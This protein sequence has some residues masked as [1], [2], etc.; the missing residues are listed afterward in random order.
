MKHT[1]LIRDKHTL[2]GEPAPS[3]HLWVKAWHPPAV[4]TPF[5][6]QPPALQQ[7]HFPTGTVRKMPCC[8]TQLTVPINYGELK[9]KTPSASQSLININVCFGTLDDYIS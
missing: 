3:L 7:G 6:T 2:I 9:T 5:K 8:Y 4:F 1:D